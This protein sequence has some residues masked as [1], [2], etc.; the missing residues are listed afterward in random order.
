LSHLAVQIVSPAA[1]EPVDLSEL[2]EHLRLDGS[3]QDAT[4]LALARA[5]REVCEAET[6]GRVLVATTYRL[7]LD[8]FPLMTYGQTAPGYPGTVEPVL[9]QDWRLS[10]ADWAIRLPRSPLLSVSSVKYYDPSGTLTTISPTDYVVD[11]ES[12]PP[13]ISPASGAYWPSAQFRPGAVQITFVAGYATPITFA[14]AVTTARGRTFATNDVVRLTT[15]GGSLPDELAE[16]TDYYV[17]GAGGVTFGLSA[18][19]GGSAIT[20]TS[21]GQGTHFASVYPPGGIPDNVRAAIKLL[22]GAWDEHRDEGGG[23]PPGVAALLGSAKT[24]TYY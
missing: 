10:P 4:V 2:K 11:A 12:D 6:G 9:R 22:V 24:G 19:Q 21:E 14:G 20:T 17:V 3:D 18:T 7:T 1:A 23:L 13:R 5:A 15:S 8:F 16:G